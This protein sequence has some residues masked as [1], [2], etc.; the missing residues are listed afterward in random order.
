MALKDDKFN[1]LHIVLTR[2]SSNM[3][4]HYLVTTV[5]I[6]AFLFLLHT[7]QAT[8]IRIVFAL[9]PPSHIHAITPRSCCFI[10]AAIVFS[11]CLKVQYNEL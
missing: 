6:T 8:S 2:R 1:L 4:M 11:H 7:S 3:P 9:S 5:P 10:T